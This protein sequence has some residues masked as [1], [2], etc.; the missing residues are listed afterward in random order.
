MYARF[1][2]KIAACVPCTKHCERIQKFKES[3]NLK[4]LYRNEL[5]KACISHDAGYS[6]SKNLAKRTIID[7]ILKGRP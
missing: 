2:F 6:N 1:T 5:G 3:G 7:K 4:Y